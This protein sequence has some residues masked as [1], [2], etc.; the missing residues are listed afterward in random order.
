MEEDQYRK[1]YHT[2]NER[3]CVFEKAIN[4][5]QCMCMASQRFN[6]ADREGVA[7]KEEDD[8]ALCQQLLVLL[9]RNAT[10]ALKLPAPEEGPLPHAKEMKVQI[11]GLLG[12][13]KLLVKDMDDAAVIYNVQQL[14]HNALKDYPRF[15]SLPFSEIMQSV[16]S[17]QARSRRRKDDK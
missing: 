16:V 5:R 4:A 10:F 12:L 2:I 14:L 13:Q 7:C 15:E 8:H 9:R 3:R 11:G 6:L 17:Y 1:T